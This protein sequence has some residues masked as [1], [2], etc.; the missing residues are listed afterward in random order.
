MRHGGSLQPN[1]QSEPP[2]FVRNV[3]D[4]L[5]GLRRTAQARPDIVGQVGQAPPGVIALERGLRDLTQFLVDLWRI[6]PGIRRP[7][8]LWRG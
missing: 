1:F 7:W 8:S 3:F 5:C 6:G 4:G 2:Q